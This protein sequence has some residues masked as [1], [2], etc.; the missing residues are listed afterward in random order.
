MDLS[1]K[2]ILDLLA[3][4]DVGILEVNA[5]SCGTIALRQRWRNPDNRPCHWYPFRFLHQI[6]KHED[7]ITQFVRP[8]GRNKQ[9]TILEKRHEGC[10]Q[11]A[12]ILYGQ[13]QDAVADRYGLV[14]WHE[15]LHRITGVA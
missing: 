1:G 12:A 11:H 13:G 7:V 15:G 5:D 9:A 14:L 3:Q 4:P 10:V 2:H 8:S 6:E